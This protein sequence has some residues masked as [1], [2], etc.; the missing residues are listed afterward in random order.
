MEVKK[1]GLKRGLKL[2]HD[3]PLTPSEK[4]ILIL[5]TEEFKTIKQIAQRRKTS[6]QAVYK[7]L[8]NIKQK[9]HLGQGFKGF[10]KVQPTINQR[11]IRLHGQEL[12]I[13]LIYQNPYY[14]KLLGK[15]NTLFLDGN[16]IR[17]YK[18]SVEVYLG[19]SFYGTT[20][21]EA[22]AKSISYIQKFLLR[23]ESDLKVTLVKNRSRNI[24]IVN[25]HYARGD[26]EISEKAH[27]EGKR[28]WV[29]AEEDGKLAFITDDSFGFKEDETVHPKTAKKDRNQIDK[30]VNDW[31]LNNPLTNSEIQGLVGQNAQQINHFAVHLKS[32][33][34]AIQTLSK[35]VKELRN[36]IINLKTTTR[37]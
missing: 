10:K 27:E 25:Q 1:R 6:V 5:L 15:S 36:E 7:H 16:T 33:V 3:T 20:T 11:D 34:E 2:H 12:N 21:Q 23:L 32:H 17:L 4:E 18:N 26:S 13:K 29:Y 24:R 19:Q 28:I 9:G 31:R 14:Q 8:K 22:D 37:K 35:T 30:Q